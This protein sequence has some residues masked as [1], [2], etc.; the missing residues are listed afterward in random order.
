MKCIEIREFLF[1]LILSELDPEVEIKVNEHLAVCDECRAE[2]SRVDSVVLNLRR[3][4]RFKPAPV[5]YE[6]IAG[7]LTVPRRQRAKLLGLPRNLTYAL[8][9]FVFGL[10]L[11]RSIDTVATKGR[12]PVRMEARQDEPRRVPFSDTVEFYAVPAKNLARI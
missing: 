6:R 5:V 9:A 3:G 4:T 1:D 10:V 2:F 7:S 11:A 8:G 12:R